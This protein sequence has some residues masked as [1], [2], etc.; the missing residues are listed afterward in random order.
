[1]DSKVQIVATGDKWI[2]YGVKT[3]SSAIQEM[4]DNSKKSLL[5][6]I[7]IISE[8]NILNKLKRALNRGVKVEVFIQDD[9]EFYQSIMDNLLELQKKYDHIKIFSGSEELMHAKVLIS[10]KKEVIIGSA[11]LTRS[12][13]SNNYELG[14][15]LED[16]RIAYELETIIKRLV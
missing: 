14:I 2:G 6:T 8:G 16:R 4:I 15:L 12:G 11:N 9:K 1:M 3:T 7:Y 10:D 13:L 5:L